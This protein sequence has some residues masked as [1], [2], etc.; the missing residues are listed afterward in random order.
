MR[1][2]LYF[3]TLIMMGYY[4]VTLHTDQST[5][6]L[7]IAHWEEQRHN[8]KFDK[9]DLSILVKSAFHSA[10]FSKSVI[11]VSSKL[12]RERAQKT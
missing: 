10:Y 4:N 2:D 9:M 8:S 6:G 12:T 3:D 11:A 1:N 7:H 5:A